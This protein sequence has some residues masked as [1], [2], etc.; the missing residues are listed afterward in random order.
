MTN[1]EIELAKE[2]LLKK[3][4]PIIIDEKSISNNS[5]L[6]LEEN[7]FYSFPEGTTTVN[8]DKLVMKFNSTIYIHENTKSFNLNVKEAHINWRST[9]ELRALGGWGDTAPQNSGD[10]DIFFEQIY[11]NDD[12]RDRRQPPN[13]CGPRTRPVCITLPNGDELCIPSLDEIHYREYNFQ[14]NILSTGGSGI[15]GIVGNRGADGRDAVC[16]RR[17]GERGYKGGKGGQGER[18]A[19]GG[20]IRFIGQSQ[21]AIN[22]KDIQILSKGG[23]GGIGGQGGPGG[24]PG[25]GR[26][27]GVRIMASG[28][29][30]GEYGE[31]GDY[32]PDGLAGSI[33][34][35]ITTANNE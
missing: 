35:N 16:F 1:K 11:F 27:C 34:V 29:H 24:A 19:N 28:R 23:S 10:L 26:D 15:A 9:I 6:I 32:G 21:S 30:H 12:D 14:I 5:E 20:D 3:V 25:R 7:E 33:D 18:G 17:D 13:R 8:I 2:I 4:T 31:Q 22:I